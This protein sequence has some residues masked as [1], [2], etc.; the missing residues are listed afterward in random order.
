MVLSR[1]FGEFGLEKLPQGE[2][3]ETVLHGGG[4]EAAGDGPEWEKREFGLTK[5]PQGERRKTAAC[6]GCSEMGGDRK[7]F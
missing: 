2:R 1:R 6:G 3:R 5:L 7:L 4:R